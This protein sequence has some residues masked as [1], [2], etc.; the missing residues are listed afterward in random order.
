M[1]AIVQCSVDIINAVRCDM[2]NCERNCSPVANR[3]GYSRCSDCVCTPEFIPTSLNESLSL[4]QT[5]MEICCKQ[6]KICR[7]LLLEGHKFVVAGRT[8]LLS[9]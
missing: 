6:V 9:S 4:I 3:K 8:K 5:A 7:G 2:E 1:M